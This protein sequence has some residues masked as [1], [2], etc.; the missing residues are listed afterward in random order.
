M[1]IL[2]KTQK[3]IEHIYKKEMDF[4]R[5]IFDNYNYFFGENSI[6]I[7]AKKKIESNNLGNSIPDGFLLNFKNS[8]SIEF[9]IIEVELSS[10]D[11]YRHIFP[12]ITKF[13]AFI[14]NPKNQAELI[15]KI[16]NIIETSNELK[17][18][19][20][21]LSKNKEIYKTLKDSIENNSSILLIIDGDKAE[22]PEIIETYT[23][24]WGEYV[25]IQKIQKFYNSTENEY[26][27]T[28]SPEFEYLDYT[29]ELEELTDTD[30]E[31]YSTYSEEAHLDKVNINVREN[32]NYIKKNLL[33][34][35][36]SI[37]FNP[38]K[39]YVGINSNKNIAFLKFSKKR[40]RAI[41]LKPYN[42]VKKLFKKYEVV[43]LTESVQKFWNGP[44]C[45]VLIESSEELDQLID[46]IIAI[47]KEANA[48]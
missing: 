47:D 40:F 42:E 11:F 18:K 43:E 27:F 10:H 20:L 12:Q 21:K 16:Y 13:F 32:Y 4:E 3:Y 35:N 17:Q 37:V 23:D 31:K 48:T 14:R 34:H 9:Y 44:S 5:D 26:I 2:K 22:L 19:F 46:T 8:N 33:A 45:A 41:L 6:L 28:V 30:E 7:D 15:E 25:K 29:I 36:K 24:T 1:I 39:Y 38:R